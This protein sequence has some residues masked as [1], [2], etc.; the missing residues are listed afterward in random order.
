VNC[1]GRFRRGGPGHNSFSHL[2]CVLS[3]VLHFRWS[4][5]RGAVTPRPSPSLPRVRIRC[6]P[7]RRPAAKPAAL[8]FIHSFIGSTFCVCDAFRC[9]LGEVLSGWGVHFREAM[10][11]RG[12]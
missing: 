3:K 4:D 9:P 12:N 11:G 2:S 5:G 6:M 8:S 7:H 1:C 10:R